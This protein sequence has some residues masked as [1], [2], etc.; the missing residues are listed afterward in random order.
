MHEQAISKHHHSFKH[1]AIVVGGLLAMAAGLVAWLEFWTPPIMH[2][3]PA[4]TT[5]AATLLPQ[6]KPLPPFSLI[7]Q[8][9]K[10]FDNQRLQGHWTFL[11]FG[12]THCPDVCPTTLALLSNLDDRLQ[13]VKQKAPYEIAFVSIDPQRDSRQR[14]AEYVG[15]FD[16]SFLGVRGDDQALQQL[17]RPLGILYQKV[18]TPNSA[19]G[20]V[21]DHSTSI[22]LIDPQGRY[23]ALFSPPHDADLMAEDFKSIT[24]NY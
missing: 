19:M 5:K 22:A 12:Y 21:M 14:L 13:S 10:T 23:Y 4:I 17:T 2:T 11:D 6:L 16:P 3:P 24:R 20:Y 8:Q 9:G 18:P 1:I 15:Y 7:D